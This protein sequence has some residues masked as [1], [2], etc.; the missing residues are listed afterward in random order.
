MLEWDDTLCRLDEKASVSRNPLDDRIDAEMPVLLYATA[1]PRRL[2]AIKI[3]ISAD[4]TMRRSISTTSELA[5]GDPMNS[6]HPRIRK[7]GLPAFPPGRTVGGTI[8]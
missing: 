7:C 4:R 5:V 8:R 3:I 6:C 1:D 2:V